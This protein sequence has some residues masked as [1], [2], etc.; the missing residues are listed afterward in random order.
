MDGVRAQGM[1]NAAHLMTRPG[2][3][4]NPSHSPN[5]PLFFLHHANLDR[6]RDKW[7]RTSPANAV[8]Y[9]GGSVQNL[10][11]YDDY[12]VGAPPNVDTTW[13]LPTCGLDTALTVNDVMSTT[14][15]RLCFLYT[16]YAAS[17]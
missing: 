16:D 1:H 11:G 7:Q 12:P 10:T 15:G 3:L 8:A 9:G 5:D 17:A 2:D 13:D 14:G 6:I 4:S